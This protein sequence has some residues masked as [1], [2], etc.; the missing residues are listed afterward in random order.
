MLDWRLVLYTLG[1][2]LIATLLCSAAYSPP[3][4]PRAGVFPVPYHKGVGRRSRRVILF[5]GY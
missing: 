4:M 3:F 2:T 1:C 5:N